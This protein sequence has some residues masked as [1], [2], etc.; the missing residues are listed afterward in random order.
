LG[1]RD[2]N[3]LGVSHGGVAVSCLI[4]IID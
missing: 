2:R 4:P 1:S 3:S